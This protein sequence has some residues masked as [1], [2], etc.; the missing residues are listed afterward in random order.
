MDF[1]IDLN[2]EGALVLALAAI[3]VVFLLVYLVFPGL[4]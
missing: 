2:W 3:V 1:M 4:F